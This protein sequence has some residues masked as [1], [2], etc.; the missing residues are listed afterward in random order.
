VFVALGLRSTTPT[1]GWIAAVSLAILTMGLL[2]RLADTASC[3]TVA[4]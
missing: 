4:R 3:P 1:G 2:R